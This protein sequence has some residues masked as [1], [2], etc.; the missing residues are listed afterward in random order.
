MAKWRKLERSL[1]VVERAR[2]SREPIMLPET[3]GNKEANGVQTMGFCKVCIK[4]Q[5]SNEEKT[6]TLSLPPLAQT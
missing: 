2:C 6:F 4:K 3:L 1:C 5:E